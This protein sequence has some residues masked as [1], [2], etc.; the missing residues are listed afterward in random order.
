[1]HSSDGGASLSLQDSDSELALELP[2]TDT[3]SQSS[4][5]LDTG[6]EDVGVQPCHELR[7]RTPAAARP[8][9]SPF[10]SWSGGRVHVADAP[11]LY[12][13][14]PLNIRLR[15]R[16]GVAPGRRASTR[17][18]SRV[19]APGDEPLVQYYGTI[20]RFPA[21]HYTPG[22]IT[23]RNKHE[24][25]T[26]LYCDPCFA[27]AVGA[28]GEVW[29]DLR[30]VSPEFTDWLMGFPPGWTSAAPIPRGAV[31]MH[32]LWS[33]PAWRVRAPVVSCFSGIGG[34]DVALRCW[35]RPAAYV[36]WD[37]AVVEV[38]RARMHEGSL[39][40][41]P[42]YSDICDVHLGD[43]RGK[44]HGVIAGFPCVDISIAGQQ[45]G[46]DGNASCLVSHVFRLADETACS[47]IFLENVYNILSM[48]HVWH[49]LF[50]ELAVRGFAV[51]WASIAAFHAGC[52]MRRK[53][54]FCY[55][56]RGAYAE[57]PFADC[58]NSARWAWV[59]SH[60]PLDFNPPGRPAPVTWLQRGHSASDVRRLCFAGNA[61]V[62]M[63]AF[64]AAQVLASRIV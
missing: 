22:W 20:R 64:L 32:P 59:E 63:Q 47:F 8:R 39:E 4:M 29:S 2:S 21:T 61:V 38:L 31:A 10:G 19:V 54:W 18:G 46:M 28:R 34:L 53:R 25:P 3:E 40:T 27:A 26:N 57:K 41:A 58:Y 33:W 49:Y 62:P 24:L 36:E 15:Q 35:C 52:P 43:L 51:H 11:R 5:V 56:C 13:A 12:C 42:I 55:A 16:D 6:S 23:Q 37:S 9:L 48:P 17:P 30:H 14:A 7:T 45:A 1:M 44:V 60:S 50:S